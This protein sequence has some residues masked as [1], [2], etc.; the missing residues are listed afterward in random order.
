MSHAPSKSTFPRTFAGADQIAPKLDK[1]CKMVFSKT[2]KKF[3]VDI[4][5]LTERDMFLCSSRWVIDD[6]LIS[7]LWELSSQR[8][9]EYINM[10]IQ[11]EEFSDKEGFK[12]QNL[13][14]AILREKK[15]MADQKILQLDAD[16]IRKFLPKV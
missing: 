15:R 16:I 14:M 12:L 10:T 9:V 5:N 2:Y 13:W 4:S 1:L 11:R 3:A 7:S 6:W 8:G